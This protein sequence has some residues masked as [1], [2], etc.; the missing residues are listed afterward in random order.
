VNLTHILEIEFFQIF[1]LKIQYISILDMEEWR[2][3]KNI[4]L[5]RHVSNTNKIQ[6][7]QGKYN[8]Y[9]V[10]IKRNSH[11]GINDGIHLYYFLME[12]LKGIQG[13]QEW[14]GS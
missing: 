4:L 14:E 13:W 8:G 3:I 11:N 12:H 1:G 5:V 9:C 7:S 6:F 10:S 2:W